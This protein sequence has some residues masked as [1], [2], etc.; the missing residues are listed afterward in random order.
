[1]PK[2]KKKV[3][4]QKERKKFILHISREFSPYV[5]YGGVGQVVSSIVKGQREKNFESWVIIPNYTFLHNLKKDLFTFLKIK[6]KEEV[7]KIPV[8]TFEENNNRVLL[9]DGGEEYPIKKVF[10]TVPDRLYQV[11]ESLT[12]SFREIFFS[13]AVTKLISKISRRSVLNPAVLPDSDIDFVHLH[14]STNALVAPLIHQYYGVKRPTIIYSKNYLITKALHD[15]SS[16]FWT[17]VTK[18]HLELFKLNLRI[19]KREV[20]EEVITISKYAIKYSDSITC[21]SN[22]MRE[23]IVNRKINFPFFDFLKNKIKF[24]SFRGGN[25]LFLID[26][27]KFNFR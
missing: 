17:I 8:Y 9:I 21:V 27:G 10:E 6:Y 3:P 22:N 20:L 14:G 16:E 15:Y 11:H 24:N 19:R 26:S 13:I 23:E 7:Y 25:Y 5:S 12:S 1:M 18:Y 4:I 2:L